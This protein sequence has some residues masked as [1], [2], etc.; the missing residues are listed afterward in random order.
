VFP[1][2][3]SVSNHDVIGNWSRLSPTQPSDPVTKQ[4]FQATVPHGA[5]VS[6][7]SMSYAVLPVARVSSD[8]KGLA[9]AVRA[10]ASIV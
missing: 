8:M 3:L 6:G 10:D 7:L 9:S 4:V 2:R 1:A 5:A